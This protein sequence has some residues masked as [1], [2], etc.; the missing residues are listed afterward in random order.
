MTRKKGSTYRLVTSKSSDIPYSTR[1]RDFIFLKQVEEIVTFCMW[2]FF[3]NSMQRYFEVEKIG[4]PRLTS[5][6]AQCDPLRKLESVLPI[7]LFNI[8][9][10]NTSATS[11]GILE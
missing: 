2:Y 1:N 5:D 8:P 6:F 9:R 7:P 11:Y 4:M 10:D 3:T